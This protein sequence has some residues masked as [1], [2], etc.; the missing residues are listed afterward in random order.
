M[1][2]KRLTK[3]VV[4][5]DNN[6]LN[7]FL[8]AFFLIRIPPFY[9]FYPLKSSLLTTHT[10]ARLLIAFIFG[11]I[12]TKSILKKKPL[13]GEKN[14]N[15]LILF[16]IY[17]FFQ[18]VSVISSVNLSSFFQRYKDIVFPGLF[19]FLVVYFK[20]HYRKIISVLLVTLVVNFFY[21]IVIF[22]AP[23]FFQSMGEVFIYQSHFDLVFINLERSRIFIETYDE[24]VIPLIVIA[25]AV[26][27][28]KREKILM[29]LMFS[30][31]VLPSFLS[32]F[33]SRILML[34]FAVFTS[35][36]FLLKK[37]FFHKTIILSAF[38]IFGYLTYIVLT[39]IFG[40]SFVDRFEMKDKKED[41][42][43]VESRINNIGASLDMAAGSPFFGVG[44][45]N[46]Y[47]YLPGTKKIRLSLFNWKNKE[48]EIAS[49][50]PHNIFAQI[51][52]ETGFVSLIFYILMIG[53]FVFY[54]WRT[55]KESNNPYPKGFIISFWTLFIYS[56]FNP[57][58]TLIYNLLFWML[59][60]LI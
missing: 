45:G 44:L 6:L 33:R 19:L 10:L 12:V 42:M 48:S 55:L 15:I 43:T 49:T 28:D 16:L 2:M 47:D 14:R 17:F 20:I 5:I 57:T 46:Y 26:A 7:F 21:Q 24:I 54:D 52:S 25:L 58:T 31:A 22:L 27:K 9:L 51:L 18:S 36:F 59:R 38:L 8:F 13:F 37:R 29:F 34:V 32:N 39:T 1:G 30:M 23:S 53:Y 50:N 60:G 40:F 41:V 3:I 56:L 4:F 11:G 35:F